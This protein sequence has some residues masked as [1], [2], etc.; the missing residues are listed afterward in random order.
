M[1]LTLLMLACTTDV[2]P[3]TTPTDVPPTE[4]PIDLTDATLTS[5]D[6]AC[7]TYVADYEA[8]VVDLQ[9]DLPF[10][11][12]LTVA[13]DGDTCVITSNAIPNHD[14][15]RAPARF[16][17]PVAEVAQRFVIPVTPVAA[18]S[19]TELVLS[20]DDAVFLNGVKL[21]LLAAACYGVGNAPLGEERIGCNQPGTP[22]RYDPMFAGN[23]FG[24]DDHNAHTQPDGAYH[25][26]GSPGA[27]FADTGDVASPVIGFAA[28]GFPIFGPY[29]EVDGVVRAARSGYTLR[30]GDRVSIDGEGA[31]PGGQHD[32]TYRDDW[33]FTD[34]GD[35][36]ACNGREHDGVYGYHVTDSYPWV[37]ACFTGTPNASFDKRQ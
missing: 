8:H 36:D 33:A 1:T 24:T 17:T 11:G 29:I 22:W 20:Y 32:G 4:G 37:L 12:A 23:G 6:P 34:A 3:A 13:V 14:F 15:N 28:D 25:Y 31:F 19:P 30:E 26:H 2:T 16:A 9:R 35:L 10:E 7:V 27:L 5:S 18:A 21:D